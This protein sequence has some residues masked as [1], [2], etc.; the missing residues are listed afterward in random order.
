MHSECPLV[1][2]DIE[3][4]ANSLSP[5]GR[6]LL[7]PLTLD[8]HKEITGEFRA[9]DW[10]VVAY[11]HFIEWASDIG[12]NPATWLVIDKLFPIDSIHGRAVKIDMHR[13]Y[14]GLS[15]GASELK[16][17]IELPDGH[18][19]S[20]TSVAILDDAS[21]T[22]GTLK[23]IE[24]A[25]NKA[26]AFVDKIVVCACRPAVAEQ[27]WAENV[28]FSCQ[29][30]TRKGQDI[31]HFRDFFP[32]LPFSGRRISSRADLVCRQ[33]R[34]LPCRLAPITF[35]NGAWLHLTSDMKMY[36][37]ALSARKE[38]VSIMDKHFHGT[39]RVED[40][41]SVGTGV[42]VPLSRAEAIVRWNTPLA[43][44]FES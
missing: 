6:E 7:L 25:V 3:I 38:F 23:C 40:L 36:G 1:I 27:Y 9:Q 35:H 29:H 37:V 18:I 32:W 44:V 11:K 19:L 21:Y 8:C 12:K 4:C 16:L 22:G 17:E 43:Q 28:A 34:S 14:I 24:A 30:L 39:A 5:L 15:S 31:L 13:S 26:G 10:P 33:S 20:G 42:G 41:L 2:D